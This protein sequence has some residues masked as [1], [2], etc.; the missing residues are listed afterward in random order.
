[1]YSLPLLLTN[2]GWDAFTEAQLSQDID[3]SI[4][5][6]GLTDAAFVMSPTLTALPGEFK[7]LEDLSGKQVGTDLVHLTVTDSSSDTY[8]VRGI[9]LF[10]EDGRL[11][12]VYGQA[13]PIVEKASAAAMLLAFDIKFLEALVAN[14]TFG[15][16]EFLYPPAA[17][18]EKGVAEIATQAE[19][20]AGTDDSRFVTPKKLAARILALFTGRSV[21]TA[22]LA[23]GGGDLSANRTIDVPAASAAEADAGAIATKAV[24]PA[25]LVNLLAKVAGLLGRTIN[26]SGLAAGG[27]DLSANRTIDVP[28]ASAAEADAG[29]IATKALTPASLVNILTSIAARAVKTITVTGGGLATG[30]GDL[31]A[32]RTITVPKASAAEV[33]AGTDDTKAVTPLALAGLG[34][35]AGNAVPKTR[36]ISTAGLASGGGDL[37]ADRTITVPS[38]TAAEAD[39]AV[40]NDKALTPASLANFVASISSLFNRTIS[41]AGLATGGGSLA[42]NRTIT[43]PKAATA[44]FDTGTDDT[45]ALTTAALA[46]VTRSLAQNGHTRV[47]PGPNGLIQQWG[48]F[49]T[50]ANGSVSVT[51]PRAFPNA[52]FVV[53][54]DGGLTDAA[55]Q[56]NYA[57]VVASTISTT[58]FSA[59]NGKGSSY[60]ATF[61]A[62][63]N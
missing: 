8:D 31:S 14:L 37:S 36:L 62:V 35:T 18:D 23:T 40:I 6:I 57:N 48:R 16:S 30:G 47:G 49:T 50:A 44:D 4:A 43:V 58:G 5:S 10:L 56:D 52:C 12:G 7:R 1:M 28:A 59:F 15:S 17:E 33:T 41:A 26:G 29:A 19:V 20:D 2:E 55:A 22:G 45:K 25:S 13:E 38:A 3:L 34:A 27:G 61:F 9:G 42:Q 11:F 54:V 46:G 53:L 24:T 39:A 21:L 51:F 63:G 32:N 60:T